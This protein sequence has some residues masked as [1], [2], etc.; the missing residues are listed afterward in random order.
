LLQAVNNKREFGFSDANIMWSL[1]IAAFLAVF[2]NLS[3]AHLE[4]MFCGLVIVG[5]AVL[6]EQTAK[7]NWSRNL[8]CSPAILAILVLVFISLDWLLHGFMLV[9]LIQ[10]GVLII[11]RRNEASLH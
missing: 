3:N 5:L 9:G 1:F 8:L 6:S 4:N 10:L 11:I 2:W 7:S